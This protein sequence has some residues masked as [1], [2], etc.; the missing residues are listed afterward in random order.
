[1]KTSHVITII[2][3]SILSAI[4]LVGLYS[5]DTPDVKKL[6]SSKTG[7][8]KNEDDL[9]F[10]Y[11]RNFSGK[12]HENIN[13]TEISS[14]EESRHDNTSLEDADEN[15]TVYKA[16]YNDI[17]QNQNIEESTAYLDESLL[18]NTDSNIDNSWVY[19]GQ[20]SGVKKFDQASSVA[21]PSSISDASISENYQQENE[22]INYD[23]FGNIVETAGAEEYSKKVECPDSLYMGGSAYEVNMLKRMG[24]PKPENY[25]GPW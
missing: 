7:E 14:N 16:V 11:E 9:E 2:F 3:L 18:V 19:D 1:M 24:C 23:E 6:N 10:T 12:S 13:D 22:N 17:S 8:F 21:S 15:Y 4:L 25:N 5:T 20:E